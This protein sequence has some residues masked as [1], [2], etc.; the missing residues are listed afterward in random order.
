MQA[1]VGVGS[2]CDMPP[3]CPPV[4]VRATQGHRLGFRRPESPRS[5]RHSGWRVCLVRGHRS[6]WLLQ[7]WRCFTP[8][9][10][11]N[12]PRSPV[13][14]FGTNCTHPLNEGVEKLVNCLSVGRLPEK[15]VFQFIY[16]AFWHVMC[17]IYVAILTCLGFIP[18][19]RLIHSSYNSKEKYETS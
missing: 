11:F 3:D 7:Q 16:L 13:E 19:S 8:A 15:F 4:R 5:G 18:S 17:L 9:H 2:A 12:P 14:Y 6:G 10:L 1:L